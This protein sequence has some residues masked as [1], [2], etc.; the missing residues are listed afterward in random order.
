VQIEDVGQAIGGDTQRV[1]RHGVRP[2]VRQIVEQSHAVVEAGDADIN[3]AVAPFQR[4]R[5]DI[6]A[7]QRLPGQFEQQTL[8]GVEEFGLAR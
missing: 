5:R 1:A 6:R 7:F 2:H 8:L 3:A 4:G